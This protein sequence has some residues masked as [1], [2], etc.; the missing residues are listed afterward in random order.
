MKFKGFKIGKSKEKDEDVL[1]GA[2]ATQIAEME[3]QLNGHTNNLKQTEK[4]LNKLSGKKGHPEGSEDIIRPH[5]PIG[6]LTLDPEEDPDTADLP[7]AVENVDT[8]VKESAEAVKLVEV[9]AE[10]A[11]P[12]PA[13]KA[14]KPQD[15]GE[16][17]NQLFSS[18]EE[19]EN[20]LASLIRALPEVDVNELMD[21]LTEIKG[22]IKDW[23]K[24]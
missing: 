7:P 18:D 22:I 21:D 6:E 4:Q 1:S 8:T 17:L 15:I 23:Q 20:P 11:P 13:E 3:N 5:G 12:P 2:M 14:S 16:S 9:S 10:K 19:E 24:K